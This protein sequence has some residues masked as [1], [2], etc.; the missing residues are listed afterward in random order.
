MSD[1][2]CRRDI[3]QTKLADVKLSK[4]FSNQSYDSC[5]STLLGL[6]DVINN[7]IASYCFMVYGYLASFNNV[8]DLIAEYLV[9]V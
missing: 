6:Y 8:Y 4:E 5:K 3:S 1:A 2:Y 9:R 7:A